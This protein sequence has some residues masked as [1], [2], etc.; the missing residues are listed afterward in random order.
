MLFDV[1]KRIDCKTSQGEYC[2][3]DTFKLII[4]QFGPD[5][6]AVVSTNDPLE[7]SGVNTKEQLAAL[8]AEF[9]RRMGVPSIVAT[10]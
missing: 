2:L 8:E 5:A 3:T 7:V 6:V 1:L 9:E 10:S 4:E